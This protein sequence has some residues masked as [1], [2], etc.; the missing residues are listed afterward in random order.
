MIEQFADARRARRVG[1]LV[2]DLFDGRALAAVE[3][4]HDLTLTAGQVEG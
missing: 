4:L 1:Q 3:D 2:P